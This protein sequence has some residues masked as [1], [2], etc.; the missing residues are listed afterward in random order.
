MSTITT[1]APASQHDT[2]WCCIY[3]VEWSGHFR[4][5]YGY[6]VSVQEPEMKW[7]WSTIH[8]SSAW[9][10]HKFTSFMSHEALIALQSEISGGCVCLTT[11]RMGQDQ[12]LTVECGTL[13]PR[14]TVYAEPRTLISQGSPQSF[15]DELSTV[16]SLWCLSKKNLID[17]LFPDAAFASQEKRLATKKVFKALHEET[18][19]DFLGAEV[20]RFGNFEVVRYMSQDCRKCD[21]LCTLISKPRDSADHSA[22]SL[23]VWIEPPLAAAEALSISCRMFN[24]GGT[25]SNTCI[26]DEIRPWQPGTVMRFAPL[27]PFTLT[28]VTV[29]KN[30]RRVAY[31]RCSVLRSIDSNITVAGPA[32]KHITAWSNKLQ[33]KARDKAQTVFFDI[34][35]QMTIGSVSHDPWLE[36]ER[37]AEGIVQEWFPSA[38]KGRF[39]A[40]ESGSN[41]EALDFLITQMQRP[42]VTGVVIADPYFDRIGVESLLARVGNVGGIRVLTSHAV[43]DASNP[44]GTVDLLAACTE[45]AKMLPPGLSI[46]NVDTKTGGGQQFHDRYVLIEFGEQRNEPRCEVWMLSNSLSSFAKRYPLV[47][48]PLST[49][50]A[51]SVAGYLADIEGGRLKDRPDLQATPIWPNHS[52]RRPTH[53]S[54]SSGRSTFPGSGLILEILAPET[55]VEADRAAT[56]VMKGL[57]QGSEPEI[58]WHVPAESLPG[59]VELMKSTLAAAIKSNDSVLHAL[60][61]WSY[62]GGPGADAYAFNGDELN[63]I[64]AVFAQ[65]LKDRSQV[66]YVKHGLEELTSAT[67]LPE[68]LGAIWGLQN[69]VPLDVGSG[70][71]PQLYFFANALWQT[72]PSD[73]VRILDETKNLGILCWLAME[74]YPR[75]ESCAMALMDSKLGVVQALGLLFLHDISRKEATSA[76]QSHLSVLTSKLANSKLP[77]LDSLLVMVFMSARYKQPGVANETPFADCACLWPKRHITPDEINRIALLANKA[78]PNKAIARIAQLAQDCPLAGSAAALQQWSVNQMLA[79]LP[80]TPSMAQNN[81]IGFNSNDHETLTQAAISTWNVHKES[82]SMWFQDEVLKKLKMWDALEPL[83]RTRNYSK[84]NEAVE[85]IMLAMQLGVSIAENAPTATDKVTFEQTVAPVMAGKLLR[86]GPELWHHFGDFH[87]RLSVVSAF[88]GNA[89]EAAQNEIPQ[90]E[91]IITQDY[92]PSL[93]KLWV[94]LKS[95]KLT[96][97]FSA[98]L[99]QFSVSPTTPSSARVADKLDLWVSRISASANSLSDAN[100]DLLETATVIVENL[101]QWRAR[102]NESAL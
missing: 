2:F 39:F 95:P 12:T 101:N 65:H 52:S 64:A 75:D 50:V 5:V 80:L 1:P 34:T 99:K 92:V 19:I 81:E 16:D 29:W 40:N 102:F 24:G 100:Q 14:P 27:E 55:P 23:I 94:I 71:T 42:G 43:G 37:E 20:G 96:R 11:K 22:P 74:A 8:E 77:E 13:E 91:K 47:I 6:A 10:L 79:R 97:Q 61:Y 21:G 26:L 88:I 32:H 4:F 31:Q 63:L 62:W 83:L 41:L 58:D 66:E 53:S 7:G 44:S 85:N 82:T 67:P 93:W 54:A 28:E 76:G 78:A 56:A 35:Q 33:G 89:T 98:D 49:D 70:A 9:H 87:G 86:L 46:S 38:T 57:L 45:C 17:L 15:S 48:T 36:S 59:V 73:L 51:K 3:A 30:G 60:A 18:S 84:W 69:G 68:S 72:S 25:K 90:I